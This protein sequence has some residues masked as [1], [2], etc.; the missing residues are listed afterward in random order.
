MLD[1]SGFKEQDMPY[2]CPE[3]NEE[4]TP[5]N[6]I[7]VGTYPKGGWRASMKPNRAEAMGFECPKCF[8]KSC[9]H[10]DKY[11]IELYEDYKTIEKL[12][13]E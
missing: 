9:F 8:T 11:S 2:R 1:F 12:K 6:C 4:L 3:C 13:N 10:A 7:G 5:K